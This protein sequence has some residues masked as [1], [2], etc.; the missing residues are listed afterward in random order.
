MY[1]KYRMEEIE[2]MNKEQKMVLKFHETFSVETPKSPCIP[3]DEVK[4]L[5]IRLIREELDEL[6]VAFLSSDIIEVADALADLLYVVNGC[7]CACG[8]DMEEIFSEVH[9]SNMTKLG[10]KK[11]EW[12][13]FIKPVG[14]SK[15]DLS[16]IIEYQRSKE[17]I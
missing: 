14:Y 16:P 1:Q 10:A 11:D 4:Y 12:G 13:K 9:R 6:I 3:S 17:S 2:E 8:L 15:A 5:R 7:A